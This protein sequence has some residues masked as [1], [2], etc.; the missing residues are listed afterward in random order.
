MRRAAIA[1]CCLL[2]GTNAPAFGSSCPGN[3]KAVG[4]SRTIT[5]HPSALPRLGTIQYRQSLPLA[6]REVVITFDDGPIPPSTNR[7]LN[8]LASECVRVTFFL[9]GRRASEHPHLVRRMYNE[10]HSI[11]THSQ[12]HPLTFD[13]MALAPAQREVRDGIASVQAAAGDPR[14]VAPFFRIPG[15]LRS[16]PVERF[17]SAQSLAVWS[18]DAVADDWHTGVT[19][20]QIVDKAIRRIDAK[21]RGVLLLHDIHP[22]TAAALPVLLKQLKRR[23]YRIVHAIPAG[24][25]PNSVPKLPAPTVADGSGNP[26][27]F[28]APIGKKKGRRHIADRNSRAPVR[29]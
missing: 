17:L 12:N 1:L 14:A 3:P 13:R 8:V 22:A 16:A 21:G 5:V 28:T 6:H 9:V 15:L 25:R 23:G 24:E 4:T 10:G 11:G 19:P 29:R 27:A 7:I 2:G 26:S 18:A 20:Q